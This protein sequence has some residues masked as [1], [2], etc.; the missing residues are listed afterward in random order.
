MYCVW[1]LVVR[2]GPSGLD[3]LDGPIEVPPEAALAME[4]G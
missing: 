1:T 2:E 3:R 4:C